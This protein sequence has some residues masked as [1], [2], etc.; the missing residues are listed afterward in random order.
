MVKVA[1]GRGVVTVGRDGERGVGGVGG[2]LDCGGVGCWRWLGMVKM[3]G[4]K[5]GDG[6]ER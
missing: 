6:G 4:L 2:V 1:G 3:A 5:A